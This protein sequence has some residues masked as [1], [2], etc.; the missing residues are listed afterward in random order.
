MKKILVHVLLVLMLCSLVLLLPAAAVTNG[1]IAFE[2][3]RDGNG[4][5]YVMN[6]DG[7]GQTRLPNESQFG[8]VPRVVSRRYKNCVRIRP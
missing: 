8:L 7:T 1:K 2:S 4:E 6:A 5:I 3:V